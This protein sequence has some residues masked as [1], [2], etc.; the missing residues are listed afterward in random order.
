MLYLRSSKIANFYFELTEKCFL[1]CIVR[2][3]RASLE[4]RYRFRP[5]FFLKEGNIF[6]LLAVKLRQ[7]ID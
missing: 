1:N 7:R 2:L 6:R 5:G 3:Q 4:T